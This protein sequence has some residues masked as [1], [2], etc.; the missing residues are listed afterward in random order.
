MKKVILLLLFYF[1]LLVFSQKD[2]TKTDSTRIIKTSLSVTD[3]HKKYLPNYS[4]L[5]PNAAGMQQL[6]DY[7]VNLAT[8][9]PDISILLYTINDGGITQ[10]VTLRY[11][12]TGHRLKSLASWTG[13]GWTLDYGNGVNRSLQGRPDDAP[14][15]ANYL[16]TPILTSDA[17]IYVPTSVITLLLIG[18]VIIKVMLS[19]IFFLMALGVK[20]VGSF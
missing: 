1:P 4:P 13:W 11:Q 15:S 19:Q 8:G 9:N 10:P 6:F 17:Q 16:T 18:Y 5:S 14:I 12:A 2:T 20:V 3:Q 7:Q